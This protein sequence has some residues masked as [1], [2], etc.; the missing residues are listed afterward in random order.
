MK[1]SVLSGWLL[2]LASC[3][4]LRRGL[5][6]RPDVPGLRWPTGATSQEDFPGTPEEMRDYL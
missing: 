4:G 2:L 6:A 3:H 5:G 1:H